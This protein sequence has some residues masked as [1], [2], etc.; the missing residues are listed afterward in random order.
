MSLPFGGVEDENFKRAHFNFRL[1]GIPH[2]KVLFEGDMPVIFPH[3]Q[4]QITNLFFK[5]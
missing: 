1:K 3:F 5:Y 4:N 2:N